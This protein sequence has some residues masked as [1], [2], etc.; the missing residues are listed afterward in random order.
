MTTKTCNALEK[1]NTRPAKAGTPNR[2]AL[3]GVPALA[4]AAQIQQGINELEGTL[5]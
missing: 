3:Y 5:K 4:G 1:E 2:R